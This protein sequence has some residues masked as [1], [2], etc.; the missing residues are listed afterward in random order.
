MAFRQLLYFSLS[1][2][3]VASA[4]PDWSVV[5]CIIASALGYALFWKGMLLSTSY[6][7][8]FLQAMIWFAA[9]QAVQV[10][11]FASDKYVGW[12]IYLF[13]SLLFLALGAQF[14]ILSLFVR[15]DPL[16]FYRILGISG[17]LALFE[18][19][20]LHLLSGY[21]WNPVGIALSGTLYGLQFASLFGIFGMSF[22]IFMTNLM[23]LRLTYAF[24]RS[25]IALWTIVAAAPY[26]F[27]WAHVAFHSK[28]MKESP[29][30]LSTLLVQ[31]SIYPEYKLPFNGSTPLSPDKQWERILDMLLPYQH[32]HPDLIVMSEA[33]VPYG[34]H[35]PIYSLQL[36][37]Q[38]FDT[39]FNKKEAL[40]PTDAPYVGNL[41][42]A[43]GLANTFS[44]DVVLGLEDYEKETAYNA[45]FLARPFSSK[46]ER[47]EKQVLV[48][49]GEYI[50]FSWCRSLL[51]KYGIAD[52]FTKGKGAN[53]LETG[54][55]PIG[56]SICYEETYGNLIRHN[57]LKGA[58]VL[59]N[60][61]ND[62]WYPSSRLPIVHFFHGR[63]RAVE[64]GVPLLRS[65]NTGVTCGV[66][67]LG[68]IVG[69]LSYETAKEFS[70]AE[71]LPLSLPLYTYSTLYTRF[72]DL[73]VVL[74]SSFS[75]CVL[76]AG[77][78]RKRKSFSINGLEVSPLRKN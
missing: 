11:W 62:V 1:F 30:F 55:V 13:L 42:W 44:A 41:Y 75:F 34:A 63:M 38:Y 60:L 39:Y 9:V 24:S 47:Y 25:R 40:P 15:K 49:M 78:A 67:S 4:Q 16:S 59:I 68:R 23:A 31:A 20:R 56:I 69:M 22:W 65:C 35:Y 33:V 54:R 51:A 12:Y 27:G 26:L 48:P 77:K 43:Q 29:D 8:R 71:A 66:D 10:S 5:A 19:A 70:P 2:L 3:V 36:V 74:L 7:I 37:E 57:R 17:G 32:I 53:V 28:H 64:G 58:G 52:S 72:G 14:G 50:P 61:T 73:P 21:S 46:V 18:W 6:K 45:A 76:C